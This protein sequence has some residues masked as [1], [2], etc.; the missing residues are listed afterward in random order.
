MVQQIDIEINDYSEK[1]G[2]PD[3]ERTI[4]SAVNDFSKLP[5]KIDKLSVFVFNSKQIQEGTDIEKMRFH[6]GL[7]IIGKRLKWDLM[8][9]YW[10]IGLIEVNI[11]RFMNS[12]DIRRRF[13]AR[14][15]LGHVFLSGPSA[16]VT[17]KDVHIDASLEPIVRKHMIWL[18]ERWK[19]FKVDS[20]MMRLFPQLT[21]QH[22][23][24]NPG[25]PKLKNELNR[26]HT[27][28]ERLLVAINLEI[29]CEMELTVLNKAPSSLKK[30]VWKSIEK[31][32]SERMEFLKRQAFQIRPKLRD[33]HAWFTQ[34]H[35]ENPE[36]LVRRVL[37][38][39]LPS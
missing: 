13:V 11:E 28:F 21:I 33:V 36:L 14:H 29:N 9:C 3:V 31:L 20:L 10:D 5:S 6:T 32:H 23:N 1:L 24:E 4:R 7:P 8:Y 37:E 16:Q 12:S 38:L 26:Y 17:L 39:S 25:F 27:P 30:K 15:E 35:L 22:M 2:L 18:L 34:E 19:E